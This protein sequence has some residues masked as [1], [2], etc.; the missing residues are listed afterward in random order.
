LGGSCFAV[1]G[2]EARRRTLAGKHTAGTCR[3]LTKEF[4]VRARILWLW[5]FAYFGTQCAVAAVVN[6]SFPTPGAVVNG[7]TPVVAVVDPAIDPNSIASVSFEY[8][9]DGVDWNLITAPPSFRIGEYLVPWSV[10]FLPVGGYFLRALLTDA[11]GAVAYSPVVNVELNAQPVA[12]FTAT[13]TSFPL[14]VHFDAK[15]SFDTDGSIVFYDWDFG[16]GSTDTSGPV[17]DH[18]YS[19]PGSYG[20]AMT[21]LDDR[22][23]TTT[24]HSILAVS[25]QGFLKAKPKNNCGCKR[26]TVKFDGAVEGQPVPGE[27]FDFSLDPSVKYP[28]GEEKKLGPFPAAGAV[29]TAGSPIV[30]RFQLIAELKDMSKPQLCEEGQRFQNT[31][32][33]SEV[34]QDWQGTLTN[35]PRYDPVVS[36][37][38]DP[39]NGNKPAAT[40]KCGAN[41][42][43]WCDDNVYHGGGTARGAGSD[44]LQP[45]QR[46]KGYEREDRIF[47]LDAPGITNFPR[48]AIG[49]DVSRFTRFD[50]IVS[51]PNGRDLC[52]CTWEMLFAV[53]DQ[54]KVVY[55]T[56]QRLNCTP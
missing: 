2:S 25:A 54:A 26:M 9:S 11:S 8:S 5:L 41:S 46:V 4:G 7:G 1:R 28:A 43:K 40:G 24:Q 34:D 23:G 42:D 22:G 30:Y 56:F 31:L 55:N 52:R 18:L 17:V 32:T 36:P 16:D 13:P 12:S 14:L 15:S 6:I 53:N 3:K 47:W 44:D 48:G 10:R 37:T 20:V 21:I 35:D 27:A 51:G 38:M 45:P 33:V 50:A 19:F 39:F 29:V 49:L